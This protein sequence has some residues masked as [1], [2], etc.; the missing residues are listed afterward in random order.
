MAI[1]TG[2]HAL[3]RML[4]AEG[5]EYIFGNPGTSETP[6]ADGIQDYPE[7]K[8]VLALQE[9]TAVGMAD[10]YARATGRP[11]FANIHIAGGLANGISALY[12]AYKGGTPLVLTAGNSDTRM[13]LSE[14][15]LSGDLVE[16]T[17]QY[18]KWSEEIRHASD[19]PMAVRR[20]FKEAK[21][22]PT[23]PVFLSFPWN[24]LDD[25]LDADI[26]PSSPG[27]YRTRPDTDA[28]A[29]ASQL[30]AQ[31]D[32]PVI[33]VGDRVAQSG[34]VDETVRV[35]EQ[36]G[37][38]VYAAAY[39]EVN[40]P[41][42]HSLYA[43]ALNLN[44]ASARRHLA[45]ADVMLAV[46]TNVFSSFLY[47]PEPFLDPTTKLIHLDS[48]AWEVEK[49]YSTEVGLLADPKAGLAELADALDQDMSA[50]AR[51]AAAT[52]TATLTEERRRANE[53]YRRRLVELAGR[54]PMA[55]EQM[56]HELGQALEGKNAIIADEAITSKGALMQA[57]SFDEPGSFY[58][59]RGGALGWAMPGALG[60][61]L[62]NPAR[63]VVAIVGDGASMYTVQALWTAS[64]FNIP[65]TYAICN[66]RAYRVL[67]VNMEIY[68]R[69]M[70]EDQE[71]QSEYVGMDFANPLDLAAIA[72]AMGVAGETVD[73]PSELGPAVE[74]SLASGMPSVLNVNI[75]GSL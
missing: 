60:V 9:G 63:P 65:V 53:E 40:F 58:G 28:L 29:R 45:G 10:G 20:A 57:I 39:S 15:V 8:Y 44:D 62:A 3:A 19:I 52:R 72:R 5:T 54:R 67:K 31:A 47:V 42:S 64:R 26:V 37:A 74:R 23:G 49:Q 41:T 17:D 38:R 34:A 6:F 35:A 33:V 24:T 16:M 73:D 27:Y 2:K 50:S 48:N 46:G 66:N 68:L 14:P 1:I 51:E 71:R 11:A 75:D 61:K 32:N 13:L 18:T 69:R 56:M 25:E 30:L 55:A 22:P 70:L 43:G 36:I 7:L 59:I 12:N 21:T 4:I